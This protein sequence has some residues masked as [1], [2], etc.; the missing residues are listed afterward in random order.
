MPEV[1]LSG[2]TPEPLMNY[3]KALGVFRIVSEQCDAE[4]RG[5]WCNDVFVLR[6]KLGFDALHDF[7]LKE[8]KPTPIVAPWGARSGFYGGKS[9]RA[10]RDALEAIMKSK[11]PRL[12]LFQDLVKRVRSLLREMGISH[13][14]EDEGKLALLSAC[15]SRLPD[16]V[17]FWLDACYVVLD[18]GRQFPPLLGTGG[19]EGSGSYVSGF[20]QQVVACLVRHEHD[21]ALCS[22]LFGDLR[23]GS[24]TDQ[25]PGHFS[26][27]AAGGANATQGLEGRVKTNPWDYLLC[28]EGCCLWASGA[29]RRLGQR[30]PRA[31]SFPFTVNI[32]GV[33]SGSLAMAEEVKPRTAKRDVAEIWLPIWSRLLSLSELRSLL[34]EGR[35]SVGTRM[36]ASGL[37]MA[38]AA[39]GLGVDRG[40]SQFK[41]NIFLMRNG[42]SFLAVPAGTV[43]VKR[44]EA[45]D[46]VQEI[47][48]WLGHFRQACESKKAPPSIKSLLRGIE[49]AIFE[50]CRYGGPTFFQ[51]IVVALGQAERQLALREGWVT[52]KVRVDPI[53]G[54]TPEWIDAADNRSPE[55]EIALALSG[56][57]GDSA[58]VLLIRANLE[59]VRFTQARD[60]NLVARWAEKDRATVWNSADLA[61][62]LAQVLARRLMDASRAGSDTLPLK[63]GSTVSL[64]T[65][66]QFL[67]GELDDSHIEDLLWGL[68]LVDQKQRPDVPPANESSGPLPRA[69]A[70]LKLL[71]LPEPLKASNQ[72]ICIKPEPRVVVLLKAGRVGEACQIAMRRLRASGLAPLPH[73]T[74]R[75]ITRDKDWDELNDAKIDGRRL[76]AALLM[77]I[78]EAS[79]TKLQRLVTRDLPN[80][81][82]E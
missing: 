45:V 36:A 35:A 59:P 19:N 17:T 32:S 5:C 62:N 44:R 78:S 48:P 14:A 49:E 42:Q 55:F 31:A 28:L 51:A 75:G 54:L 46:L 61:T 37:D 27:T 23:H 52:N 16:Q 56:I 64:E 47:D 12:A 8:Y 33:G 77:P 24:V 30:G 67:A 80:E 10:A 3:L 53:G 73:P 41:R 18:N 50:F 29:V 26:G 82:S 70:L 4:A 25:T 15:R 1:R 21:S 57:R 72:E 66:R 60:S 76:A 69:Y 9:E 71:F 81:D 11:D 6:S 13:K 7:I 38:R 20:A 79:I 63:S 74:S 65:L 2:C 34:A 68:A 40:I 58:G 22:A 39:A 43:D